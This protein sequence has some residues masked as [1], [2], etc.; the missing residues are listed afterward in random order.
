MFY[1]IDMYN[2]LQ[3]KTQKSHTSRTKFVWRG[4]NHNVY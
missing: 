2:D 1:N 3:A 4:S